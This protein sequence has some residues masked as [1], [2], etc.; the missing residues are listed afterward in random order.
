M[1]ASLLSNPLFYSVPGLLPTLAIV[2]TPILEFSFLET[3]ILSI[4]WKLRISIWNHEA[5]LQK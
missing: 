4:F 1:F 2:F 3:A 5:K